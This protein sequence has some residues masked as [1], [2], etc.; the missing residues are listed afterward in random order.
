MILLLGGTID[1]REIAKELQLRSIDFITS[2]VSEYGKFLAEENSEN[3]VQEI[4]DKN[5]IISFI[6]EKS[7]S[8]VIDATH[9]FAKNVSENAIKATQE[10]N[11]K[12][13]RFERPGIS[14]KKYSRAFF[15]ESLQEASNKGAEIGGNVLLTIGSRGL[16]DLKELIKTKNVYARVLPE[17][18]S[19]QA[20]ENAGIKT[21]NIIAMQGPF[22][23]DFNNLII[24]EKNI[25]L[26]ITK[27]SGKAGGT[28]QKITSAEESGI[29]LIIIKRPELLYPVVFN[30][31]NQVLNKIMEDCR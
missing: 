24:K 17:I 23:S 27:E 13:Y 19:I 2:T 20:C 4:M 16:N 22:S 14:L 3:V 15:V 1:S 5:R 9:P 8:I 31:I 30:D 21:G 11:I 12:Y 26:M 25:D 28:I 10:C 6:R 7:I 29:N 18:N